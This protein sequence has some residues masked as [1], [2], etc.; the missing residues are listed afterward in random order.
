MSLM[1]AATMALNG[2]ANSTGAV[3][4]VVDRLRW[5]TS[6]NSGPIVWGNETGNAADTYM[7]RA[8]GDGTEDGS[9]GNRS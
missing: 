8:G 7:P 6:L 2:A 5:A 4:R 9:T 3:D 1:F